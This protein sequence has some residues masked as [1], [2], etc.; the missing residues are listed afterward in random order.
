MVGCILVGDRDANK[1]DEKAEKILTVFYI[2]VTDAWV[3]AKCIKL[4]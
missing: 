4:P 1:I 2:V 3:K